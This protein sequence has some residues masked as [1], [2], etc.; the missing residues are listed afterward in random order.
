M[1][2]VIPT[3]QS[4][5]EQPLN[6]WAS[7]KSQAGGQG[8]S[9]QITRPARKRKIHWAGTSLKPGTPLEPTKDSY[10]QVKNPREKR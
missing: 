4:I 2:E 6:T 7:R 1:P 5:P 9:F 8:R 3:A 10:E